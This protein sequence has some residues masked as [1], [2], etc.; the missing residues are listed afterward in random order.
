MLR[1]NLGALLLAVLG[2]T[3]LT[4]KHFAQTQLAPK[5]ATDRIRQKATAKQNLQTPGA[6]RIH[7]PFADANRYRPGLS[8]ERIRPTTSTFQSDHW[9]TTI[10]PYDLPTVELLNT[11]SNCCR[12][13]RLIHKGRRHPYLTN[14]PRRVLDRERNNRKVG[15]TTGSYFPVQV[16]N[17]WYYGYPIP[18][19]NPWDVRMIRD[20]LL[21][22]GQGYY[23]WTYGDG[24]SIFDTLRADSQGNI[25]K[26]HHGEDYLWFDFR[27]DSGAV[28]YFP[29]LDI[30]ETEREKC[31]VYV[32]RNFRVETPAGTF[33]NCISF[34]FDIY[35]EKDEEMTYT[36]AED[37]GPIAI[38][39][40]FGG[41][42]RLTLAVVNGKIVASVRH[43]KHR[44]EITH[45]QLRNY[46][47]PFNRCT[48]IQFNLSERAFVRLR[49][50]DVLGHHL[51]TLVEGRMAAGAQSVSWDGRDAMGRD[52]PSGA[53]F[54][55]LEQ[56]GRTQ[57]GKMV[58][59]R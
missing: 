59:M 55:L 23:V 16:G 56:E 24:V 27:K 40:G 48:T 1:R 39:Y 30:G 58:L 7:P 15:P 25:W 12:L 17:T 47:N 29:P 50:L 18:P 6:S 5:H 37:V 51:R 21:I 42:A 28:Y 20:S 4:S 54:Y 57:V 3:A 2:L 45:W 38:T 32:R 8:S 13:Q 52:V 33:D 46:P 19:S 34:K 49:I 31:K 41:T 10:S 44:G 11:G 14:E 36:F 26:Y 53:Y 22:R 43:T 9:H 35:Q